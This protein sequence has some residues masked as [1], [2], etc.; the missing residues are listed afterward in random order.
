MIKVKDQGEAVGVAPHSLRAVTLER[1][2]ELMSI[3]GDQ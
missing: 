2:S 3:A 1:M